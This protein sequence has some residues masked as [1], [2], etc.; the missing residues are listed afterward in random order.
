MSY[1]ILRLTRDNMTYLRLHH[2][3]EILN[4]DNRKLYYQKVDSFQIFE[5]MRSLAYRLKLFSIMKIHFIVS[6]T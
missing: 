1:M 6:I 5:K 4:L 3:Y 2:K